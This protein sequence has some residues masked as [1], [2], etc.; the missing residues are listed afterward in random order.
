[1]LSRNSGRIVAVDCFCYAS[2]A[3]RAPFVAASLAFRT[4]HAG[5]RTS[6]RTLLFGL[7]VVAMSLEGGLYSVRRL[8]EAPEARRHDSVYWRS[9]SRL[10]NGLRQQPHRRTG[11]SYVSSIFQTGP[12]VNAGI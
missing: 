11:N 2:G 6:S 7:A 4:T 9:N 1:M 12:P 10:S 8:V 3:C 5:S